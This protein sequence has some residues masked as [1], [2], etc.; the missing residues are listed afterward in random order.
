MTTETRNRLIE[1]LNSTDAETRILVYLL[2]SVESLKKRGFI[3][4][5]SIQ[6]LPDAIGMWEIMNEAGFHI[7]D[8]QIKWGMA[9]L[10]RL[11]L[12]IAAQ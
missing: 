10:Q 4:G 9:T 8:D 1:K 6:T 7:T 12:Y 2:G 11:N 3:S 5:G